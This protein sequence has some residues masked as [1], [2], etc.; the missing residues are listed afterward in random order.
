MQPPGAPP[1]DWEQRRDGA[2]RLVID[3][4]DALADEVTQLQADVKKDLE[5]Y[6]SYKALQVSIIGLLALIATLMG[7]VLSPTKDAA[8]AAVV[9]VEKLEG[10]VSSKLERFDA[11]LEKQDAKTDAIWDVVGE[12]RPRSAAKAELQ[13]RTTENEAKQ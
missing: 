5:G 7:F 8:V 1:S 4:L 12:G 10:S 2:L 3:K 13:R 6:V 9:R 11:R